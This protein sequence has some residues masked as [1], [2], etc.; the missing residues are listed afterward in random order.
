MPSSIS[1]R[2]HLVI[3]A[4]ASLGVIAVLALTA[5]LIRAP[6]PRADAQSR[7]HSAIVGTFTMSVGMGAPQPIPGTVT[8]AD[9]SGRYP[10]VIVRVGKSGRFEAQVPSGTWLVTGHS[11]RFEVCTTQSKCAPG[12]CGVL[13]PIAVLPDRSSSVNL[14]CSG[15]R[16]PQPTAAESGSSCRPGV[17]PRRGL[18]VDVDLGHLP[19]T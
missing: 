12:P 18:T 19:G 11:P 10:N 16:H 7:H 3:A 6:S 4:V 15:S 14:G 1:T 13:M 17:N 9:Q 2:K 8:L 5:L